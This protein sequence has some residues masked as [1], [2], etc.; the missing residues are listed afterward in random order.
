MRCTEDGLGLGLVGRVVRRHSHGSG[1]PALRAPHRPHRLSGLLVTT[2]QQQPGTRRRVC[3]PNRLHRRPAARP[4]DG[5]VLVHQD[6]RARALRGTPWGLK[7]RMSVTLPAIGTRGCT[8]EQ[9]P[10]LAGP[11]SRRCRGHG[12]G[13]QRPEVANAG[14]VTS[15][16]RRHSSPGDVVTPDASLVQAASATSP[17][18][19]AIQMTDSEESDEDEPGADKDRHRGSSN[20][21][22]RAGSDRAGSSGSDNKEGA[23]PVEGAASDAAD[24]APSSPAGSDS[25]TEPDADVSCVR[26]RDPAAVTAAA[27]AAKV[28]G[29]GKVQ[30]AI[31]TMDYMGRH[32]RLVGAAE[33][34]QRPRGGS[35]AVVQTR[36]RIATSTSC[37]SG[38][39]A[40]A[41]ASTAAHEMPAGDRGPPQGHAADAQ[42][43]GGVTPPA[44]STSFTRCL[45]LTV[46]LTSGAC[47]SGQTLP[48][49]VPIV[50]RSDD[51]GG[52]GSGGDDG[53][54]GGASDGGGP[55]VTL[56]ST[57]GSID[58]V[59]RLGST[60]SLDFHVGETKRS[61]LLGKLGA[62]RRR[63]R[64]GLGGAGGMK[65]EPEHYNYLINR[66]DGLEVGG[67]TGHSRVTVVDLQT[68][69]AAEVTL[70]GAESS[71][72]RASESTVGGMGARGWLG[73]DVSLLVRCRP[74]TEIELT[75]QEVVEA[76]QKA[77]AGTKYSYLLATIVRAKASHVPAA[78]I[79][80]A[81]ARLKTL[82][83]AKPCDEK[84]LRRKL[85]WGAVTRGGGEATEVC[86][87][88]PGCEVGAQ[89]EGEF[90]CAQPG[91]RFLSVRGVGQREGGGEQGQLCAA[92]AGSGVCV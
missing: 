89:H 24:S 44:P 28:P 71:P 27:A 2:L 51:S 12:N 66:L 13:R 32:R 7:H 1:R 84:A 22:G 55:S 5:S 8:T 18:P 68:S 41:A 62:A 14:A 47:A 58:G 19:F 65:P 36:L 17:E 64:S 82:E 40:T 15:L 34:S 43:S 72:Q 77:M 76:L 4:S 23:E 11:Q 38:G 70:G 79:A 26:A 42:T 48:S 85:R 69:C 81:Q 37:T 20:D 88:R 54:G 61:T 29:H 63:R 56:I 87:A 78:M 49:A 91:R 92:C 90:W 53:G 86:C 21:S 33:K 59:L 6:L 9:Q 75:R 50:A 31:R 74:A 3:T 16:A 80:S 73:W 30:T 57:R 60:A 39:A 10:S 67:S 35:R 45:T 52:G 83:V 46:E 25:E